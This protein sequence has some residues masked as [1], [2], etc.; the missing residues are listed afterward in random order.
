MAVLDS[1]GP[2][3]GVECLETILS[4]HAE[5]RLAPIKDLHLIYYSSSTFPSA[6]KQ[7][8]MAA[9]WK[10]TSWVGNVRWEDGDDGVMER[11]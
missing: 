7:K 5:T 1:C 9:R 11:I 8:V 6:F 10:D 2:N 3:G 4:Y